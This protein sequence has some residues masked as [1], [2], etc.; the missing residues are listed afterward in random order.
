MKKRTKIAIGTT[1]VILVGMGAYAYI[2]QDNY[3]KSTSE[4]IQRLANDT[5][6]AIGRLKD[7]DEKK[8][9]EIAE[10]NNSAKSAENKATEAA[11]K[12]TEAAEKATEAAKKATEVAEKATQIN[13]ATEEHT[14]TID[15][16]NA[17]DVSERPNAEINSENDFNSFKESYL[18]KYTTG[19]S[20][21]DNAKYED[22]LIKFNNNIAREEFACAMDFCQF[23]N[24]RASHL[25]EDGNNYLTVEPVEFLC[26]KAMLNHWPANY[27]RAVFGKNPPS[28][29]KIELNAQMF[30]EKLTVYLLDLNTKTPPFE[31]LFGDNE[32]LSSKVESLCG[33]LEN[34]KEEIRSGT[35]TSKTTDA[36]INEFAN[37]IYNY[38]GDSELIP[39]YGNKIIGSIKD[40]FQSLGA[41]IDDG[42]PL[43]LHVPADG[44]QR[45]YNLFVVSDQERNMEGYKF[46]YQQRLDGYEKVFYVDSNLDLEFNPVVDRGCEK[47]L[48]LMAITLLAVEDNP[49]DNGYDFA[50]AC[51]IGSDAL[52]V[53]TREPSNLRLLT[54]NRINAIKNANIKFELVNTDRILPEEA[55]LNTLTIN[56][57]GSQII[58][59]ETVSVNKEKIE[60]KDVTP[61]EM[62]RVVEQEQAIAKDFEAK[63]EEV[64]NKAENEGVPA[65]REAVSAEVSSEQLTKKSEEYGIDL[66]AEY[67]QEMKVALDKQTEGE[68]L[69][70]K[71]IQEMEER[72]K[73]ALEEALGR[74]AEE[75]KKQ[76][77][78]RVQEGELWAGQNIPTATPTPVPTAT[79]TPA[80]A[81]TELPAGTSYFDEYGKSPT[82]FGNDTDDMNKEI[83]E[84]EYIEKEKQQQQSGVKQLLEQMRGQLLE[85]FT[86]NLSAAEEIGAVKKTKTIN[87]KC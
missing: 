87:K 54:I 25:E 73:K 38:D 69:R 15:F 22:L 36:I 71:M 53:S 59:S 3:N 60:R 6:A 29:E 7:K 47:D 61:E 46:T 64:M 1:S 81:Q 26:Y 45:G 56:P 55:P 8:L 42:E 86:P 62:P 4:R 51:E 9:E 24:S 85:Q 76:E 80:P 28:A 82:H 44:N 18:K 5:E 10:A 20:H 48:Q 39:N 11:E 78:R 35:L 67:E 57:N 31:Y 14:A 49:V 75:E 43:F 74:A 66:D 12:A 52:G 40:A 33:L 77:E 34:V 83:D 17:I 23:I 32:I 13:N 68:L 21:F 41:N 65:L 50:E 72:N 79:P 63:N 70:L 16:K 84:Q 30:L 2:T 27:C 19:K 37:F 58:K